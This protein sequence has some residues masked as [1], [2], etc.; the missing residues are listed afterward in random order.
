MTALAPVPRVSIA[1]SL[2]PRHVAGPSD[3]PV[4]TY[5][6][7]RMWL[8]KCSNPEEYMGRPDLAPLEV[9]LIADI[10]W[11]RVEQICKDLC[12]DWGF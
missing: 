3:P 11:T 5:E 6:Q 8:W 10:Y 12:S 2:A 9:K 4:W 7:A 1:R